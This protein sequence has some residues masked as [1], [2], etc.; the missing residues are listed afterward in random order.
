MIHHRTPDLSDK[1]V[2]L[3]QENREH[4][5]TIQN[6]VF[7]EHNGRLFLVGDVPEGGSANDW[8]SG[9]KAYVSWDHVQEF[10]VFDSLEEYFARLS[11]GWS[12]E[13]LQ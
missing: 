10:I 3:Y 12:D 13:R 8:L 9:L 6:A 1:I 2:C 5:L 4:E 7:E 11:R